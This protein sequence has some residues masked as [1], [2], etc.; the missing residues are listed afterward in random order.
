MISIENDEMTA[1]WSNDSLT[2]NFFETFSNSIPKWATFAKEI[3][4]FLES[5]E[6]TA[7]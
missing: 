7:L 1:L 4:W 6:I 3:I 5:D 2:L